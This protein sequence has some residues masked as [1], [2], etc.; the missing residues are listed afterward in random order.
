MFGGVSERR[1]PHWHISAEPWERW[2]LAKHV[3]TPR[4][5]D[6]WLVAFTLWHFRTVWERNDRGVGETW[7]PR[8]TS[9]TAS[10]ASICYIQRSRPEM[11]SEP[12]TT[13]PSDHLK[14]VLDIQTMATTRAQHIRVRWR[15][16]PITSLALSNITIIK[17]LVLEP[18]ILTLA[19]KN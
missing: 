19:L 18:V 15:V 14:R 12:V 1:L 4:V 10:P 16:T 7:V 11:R 5:L 6:G 9:R 17:T 13:K 2:S 8:K 3:N